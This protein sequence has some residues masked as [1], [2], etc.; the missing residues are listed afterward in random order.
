MNVLPTTGD[1]IAVSG[2]YEFEPDWL[3]GRSEVA[4]VVAKLIPGQ[5]RLPACVVL[6]D[7]P[8]TASGDVKGK[9]ESRTGSYLVLEPRYV[10]QEWESTGT[11]HVELCEFEPED[12]PWAERPTGAWVESHA[13]YRFPAW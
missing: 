1:R 8:L 5:N 11:V 6:L 12:K 7:Q 13:T 4:G 3:G 10:G 2:G 9:R